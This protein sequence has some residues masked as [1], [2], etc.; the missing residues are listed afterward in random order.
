MNKRFLNNST[1]LA[2]CLGLALPTTLPVQ[3][4]AQA[5]VDQQRPGESAREYQQRLQSARQN[6][7]RPAAAD[8]ATGATPQPA[9]PDGTQAARQAARQAERDAARA[10]LQAERKAEREAERRAAQDAARAEAAGQSAREREAAEQAARQAADQDKRDAAAE[11]ERRAAAQA[12]R[13]AARQA[14]RQAE[15]DAARAELQAQRQAE[16]QAERQ[17]AR[18]AAA[19]AAGGQGAAQVTNETVTEGNSRS[20]SEEFSNRVDQNV[21][22]HSVDDERAYAPGGMQDPN[23]NA[24]SNANPNAPT[25]PR[26]R[27]DNNNTL[28]TVGTIALLGL[29]AYAV[30]KVMSNG[31]RVVSNSGDRVVVERNGEFVV[32]KDDDVLIRRPGSD[33][34]TETFND[35]STRSTVS[36]ADGVRIV[37][38]RAADG[39]V[40]RRTRIMPN[41]QEVVLFDD[42][43]SVQDVVVSELPRASTRSVASNA[44]DAA[45]ERALAAD[46]RGVDRRFSLS[47]VRDITAVRDLVPEIAVDQV[48][49]ETG[50][51]VIRPEE[52]RE[53][54]NLGRAMRGAISDNP[55]AVFLVEGHTD[56]VGGAGYNLALSDRRAET[57][58]LALSEYFNVPPENMIVQGYGE[59]DLKEFTEGASRINRRAAV[60]NIT[61][62][63]N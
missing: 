18:Q 35:G 61:A 46:L 49:F 50:S 8:G 32:L 47:Q 59:S 26:A 55:G 37:T 15:R 54:G 4:V 56:A 52:A 3:A 30:G 5:V 60:R 11:A 20:S 27:S 48:N 57:L 44:D 14:E 45:L 10:A 24:N 58:A 12:E 62:L 16:R 2:L 9:A 1:A 33:V 22:T 51:A 40:L 34:K 38:I 41:G 43:R 42:T 36:N 19:A 17:A 21:P 28:R 63:L 31:D 29:G 6:A 53:L 25:V 39:T 23:A 13:Q 7:N